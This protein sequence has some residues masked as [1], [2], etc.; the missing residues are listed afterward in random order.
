MTLA[1]NLRVLFIT[2]IMAL[3]STVALA[4]RT[5]AGQWR[6][7]LGHNVIIVMDVLADD[8]WA[9]QTVQDN[10]VVA[11]FAG[12]YQQKKTN[13]TS[14]SIVFTPVKSKVS[15]EHGAATTESD[16]YNLENNGEVL[17]LV[18][19]DNEQMLFRKQPFATH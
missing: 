16:K 10:K 2:A 9:S 4:D 15:Q 18:T 14:G 19:A 11:E 7:D 12:T 3:P 1:G 13:D 6:A 17:R 8:H 5:I